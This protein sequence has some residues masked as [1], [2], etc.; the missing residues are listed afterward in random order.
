MS[1]NEEVGTTKEGGHGIGTQQI[2][3]MVKEMKG[4]MEIKSQEK[5]GTE[6]KLIFP[7]SDPPNWFAEKIELRKGDIVVVLDTD[8]RIHEAWKLRFKEYEEHITVKYFTQGQEA[9][10]Y[11]NTIEKKEKVKEF[12]EKIK[13]F[14]FTNKTLFV[15]DIVLVD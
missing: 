14:K 3:D 2:K 15:K 12:N 13:F 1:D 9:I 8:V 11:I 4:K 5:V 6:F 10:D 7:Q